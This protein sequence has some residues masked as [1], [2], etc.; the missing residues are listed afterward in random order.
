[1]SKRLLGFALFW[2]FVSGAPAFAHDAAVTPEVAAE[3]SEHLQRNWVGQ[4]LVLDTNVL[5]NDPHALH[6]FPGAHIVISG[7]VL[8]ELDSKKID[9]NL[10][11]A[12]REF[13][14]ELLKI[15]ERN[16]GHDKMP[17]GDGAT[18]TLD[19]TDYGKDLAKTSTLDPKKKDN[20][21]LALAKGYTLKHGAEKVTVISNDSY[22][23]IK[24]RG[25]QVAAQ[26]FEPHGGRVVKADKNEEYI[27]ELEISDEAMATFKAIRFV[28][29]PL[30]FDV[31]PNEFVILKS[32]STPANEDTVVRFQYK[33]EEPN[34]DKQYLHALM[35]F[36]DWQFKPLNLEQRM[37]LDVLMDPTVKLVILDAKAGT[38][39]TF[40]TMLAAYKQQQAGTYRQI[41]VS[42]P[43][44]YVG[45]GPGF[46]PGR[47]DEK[48]EP[49]MQPYIDNLSQIKAGP[50]SEKDKEE[51]KAIKR[52]D[53][54]PKGFELL[55]FA[56]IRGRTL[57]DSMIV[58]DEF[59]NTTEHEAKTILTRAGED[60]KVVVIGDPS[61]IDLSPTHMNASNNGLSLTGRAMLS[62]Q[63][64]MEERSL[65][66]RVKLRNG[67]RSALAEL[68]SKAFD[69]YIPLD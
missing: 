61:Q 15:V 30:D 54:L 43:S 21:I 32:P 58:I 57:P 1:M 6:K 47:M 38:G 17:I 63:L 14:R 12:A 5:L 51:R 64:N 34:P 29:K 37:A 45:E 27:K 13:S 67:V 50:R 41:Y 40:L 66:A 7:T 9:R 4:Y 56:F 46:L 69:Q 44:V 20:E 28:K 48:F 16:P 35:D 11:F 10:G 33:R 39:K 22:V 65:A 23:L 55:P 19:F 25:L 2:G 24:A 26:Q 42:K 8:E 18:L 62:P 36:S 3:C 52:L 31:A 60:T 59:Q 53:D 68:S 49:W